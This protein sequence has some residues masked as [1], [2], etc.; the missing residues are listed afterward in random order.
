MAKFGHSDK[1]LRLFTIFVGLISIWQ[2][3][4]ITLEIFQFYC[5]NFHCCKC[6][7]I[8]EISFPFGHTGCIVQF[9]PVGI[10]RRCQLLIYQMTSI[11]HNDIRTT[12]ATCVSQ[13]LDRTS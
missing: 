10:A 5:A 11:Y 6:P 13:E 9:L 7:S 1:I 8:E 4:E 3:F 12:G 2:K